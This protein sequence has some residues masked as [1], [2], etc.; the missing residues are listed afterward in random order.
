M[1]EVHAILKEGT[2]YI[3]ENQEEKHKYAHDNF[4]SVFFKELN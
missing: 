4:I 2:K 1:A 3:S